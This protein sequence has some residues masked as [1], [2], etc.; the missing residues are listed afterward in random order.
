MSR[1]TVTSTDPTTCPT[2][3]AGEHP[4]TGDRTHTGRAVEVTVL[5]D[6]HTPATAFLGQVEDDEG[7]GRLEVWLT[8]AD[9]SLA[10]SAVDVSVLT[11]LLPV[12][13]RR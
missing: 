12:S 4:T 7:L 9:V 1:S 3:C 2:W 8:T 10:L 13:A 6:R 5:G 11:G